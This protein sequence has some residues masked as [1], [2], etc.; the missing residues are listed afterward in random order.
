MW[1]GALG[2]TVHVKDS[3]KWTKERMIGRAPREDLP[4]RDGQTCEARASTARVDTGGTN[5]QIW[6]YCDECSQWYACLRASDGTV[7]EWGCPVCGLPPANLE[8]RDPSMAP[9][10]EEPKLATALP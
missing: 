7:A 1:T 9:D 4:W 6:G 2:P 8:P 10:P 3:R 5:V